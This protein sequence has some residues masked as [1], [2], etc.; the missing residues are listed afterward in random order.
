MQRHDALAAC[1]GFL[2]IQ[3][4]F[5]ECDEILRRLKSFKM[6][7]HEF[8]VQ[9]PVL[10]QSHHKGYLLF[11]QNIDIA[12]GVVSSVQ[13]GEICAKTYLVQFLDRGRQRG[14]IDNIP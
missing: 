14:E 7:C 1:R 13:D 9:D 2:N 3:K 10:F 11:I 5:V 4:A 6:L 12:I 8:L